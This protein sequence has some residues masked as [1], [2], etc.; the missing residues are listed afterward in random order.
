MRRGLASPRPRGDCRPTR[1]RFLL[2]EPVRASPVPGDIAARPFDDL[3][4]G[5]PYVGI[6]LEDRRRRPRANLG[7]GRALRPEYACRASWSL[8]INGLVVGATDAR[9]DEGAIRLAVERVPGPAGPAGDEDDAAGPAQERRLS[10]AV[11]RRMASMADSPWQK[12]FYARAALS[13]VRRATTIERRVGGCASLCHP[14]HEKRDKVRP[15][16]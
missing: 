9:T 15:G 1:R 5:G 4:S 6:I 3:S 14:G 10:D 13:G 16:K 7:S 2:P 12:E 11:K 8:S